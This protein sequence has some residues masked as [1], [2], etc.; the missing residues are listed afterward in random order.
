[1]DPDLVDVAQ[2]NKFCLELFWGLQ[3]LAASFVTPSPKKGN[4][5]GDQFIDVDLFVDERKPSSTMVQ[6]MPLNNGEHT[7]IPVTAKMI[8]SAV[9]IF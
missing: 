9:N 6:K 4:S 5:G 3:M 2:N 8:H 7:L 1:V